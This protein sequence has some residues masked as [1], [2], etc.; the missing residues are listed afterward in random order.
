MSRGHAKQS[1]TQET[2]SEEDTSELTSADSSQVLSSKETWGEKIKM[3]EEKGPVSQAFRTQ[4]LMIVVEK[5]KTALPESLRPKI[6]RS[7]TEPALTHSTSLAKH[8]AKLSV[9]KFGVSST[10]CLVSSDSYKSC[11]PRNTSTKSEHIQ[12]SNPSLLGNHHLFI[13]PFHL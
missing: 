2:I 1:A 11:L 13:R 6:N 5:I 12:R 10:T 3:A 8:T 4:P 7:F 9:E